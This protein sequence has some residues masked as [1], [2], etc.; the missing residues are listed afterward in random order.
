MQTIFRKF[1]A[2]MRMTRPELP[3]SA[4]VCVLIGQVLALDGFPP[5]GRALTGFLLGVFLS[6]SAMVF[7]DLFDLEVDRINQPQRPL[8]SGLVQPREVVIFGLITALIALALAWTLNPLAFALSMV[9]WLLGFAYNWRVKSA[10]LWGNL[11]VATSVG[12]TLIMGGV[13]V[14]RL[15]Q[16]ALWIFALIAFLFDLGEE[17]AGDAMDMEGDRLRGSRSLAIRFG[18]RAALGVSCALFGVI[19][20]LTLLPLWLGGRSLVYWLPIAVTDL[21]IVFFTVR[22]L[23]APTPRDGHQ[24]MRGLYL[25]AAIGLAAFVF[26]A[27]IH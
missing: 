14:G 4:G 2:L 16:P 11:I 10:G 9:T 19:I 8:P 6:G 27:F 12:M 21:L 18:K 22:L 17:I 20:L 5:L 15:D 25:S 13:S 3:L 26:G 7:N 1:L 23:R 24:A